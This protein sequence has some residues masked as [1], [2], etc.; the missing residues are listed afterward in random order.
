[1]TWVRRHPALLLLGGC[2]AT[3]VLFIA[4]GGGE[5]G[6]GIDAGDTGPVSCVPR[7]V[8]RC[9]G[10]RKCVGQRVC[11]ASGT[12][13]GACMCTSLT[14]G[15]VTSNGDASSDGPTSNDASSD[16]PT[17]NDASSDGPTS[18]AQ[19]SLDPSDPAP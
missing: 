10:P 16:G 5:S 19:G 15:A 1:M 4:C 18:N 2:V 11:L 7:T 8:R 6:F 3:T 17:S 12:E 14:D 9:L 13:Y